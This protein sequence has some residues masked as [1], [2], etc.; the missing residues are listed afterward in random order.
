L[1]DINRLLND[2][3]LLYDHHRLLNNCWLGIVSVTGFRIISRLRIA[4]ACMNVHGPLHYLPNDS[5]LRAMMAVVIT[6]VI[7]IA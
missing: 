1:R 7:R 2:D 5:W 4:N 3:R 6:V